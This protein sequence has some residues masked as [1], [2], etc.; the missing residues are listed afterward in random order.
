M[1]LIPQSTVITEFL[2]LETLI[3][4]SQDSEIAARDVHSFSQVT[5]IL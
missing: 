2:M 5:L 4:P 3:A 1:K